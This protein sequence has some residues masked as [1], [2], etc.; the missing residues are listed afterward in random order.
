M[1][2]LY[3]ENVCLLKAIRYPEYEF[4]NFPKLRT[5]LSIHLKYL[6]EV[7]CSTNITCIA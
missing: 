2:V 5:I 3:D 4:I 1:F 6:D 7:T